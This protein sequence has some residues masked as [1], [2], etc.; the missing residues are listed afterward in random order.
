[1]IDYDPH[2]W[3][4]H[5]FDIKGSMVREIT[6]R[7]LSC[8]AWS[9]IV[10]A[11]S[12]SVAPDIGIPSTLHSLVGLA[13]GLLLVFRTNASYDRFWEGRRMWGAIV[14]ESRNLTRLTAVHLAPEPALRDAITGWTAAFAY[15][16]MNL[17]REKKG[18]GPAASRLPAEEVA[19]VVA[20]EHVPLAIATRITAKLVEARDRGLVSDIVLQ[21][22]DQNVQQLID[23]LGACERIARTPLPFA[24]MVH[25]RRALILYCFGLPFA[26]VREFGWWTVFDTLVIAYVFFGIEEIGV[27]IENPFGH[28]DNDLPLEAI[29]ATIERNVTALPAAPADAPDAA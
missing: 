14:N 15:A 22:L 10:V 9:A 13:L 4:S 6:G 11:V 18:I 5:F 2:D 17:L 25:V 8:V 29:C 26:L 3:W 16:S 24:Y 27:E 23:Y 12:K 21:M 1:M 19:A 28:D 20:A 7:V